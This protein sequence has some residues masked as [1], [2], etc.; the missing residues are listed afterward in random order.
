M[1]TECLENMQHCWEQW[2]RVS[3]FWPRSNRSTAQSIN[4]ARLLG[5]T[6]T[7]REHAFL[8][9]PATYAASYG[10]RAVLKVDR[11]CALAHIKAGYR[12]TPL[13]AFRQRA[14]G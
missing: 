14:Q 1:A 13:S 2:A 6:E 5:K 10:F 12:Q 4:F 7:R 9:A 3:G 8:D 11:F